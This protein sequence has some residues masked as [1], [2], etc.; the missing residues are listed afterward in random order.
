MSLNLPAHVRR[1]YIHFGF[2]LKEWTKRYRL[3]FDSGAKNK[4]Q[5]CTYRMIAAS[6][7]E[8]E[9]RRERERVRHVQRKIEQERRKHD[10]EQMRHGV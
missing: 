7:A 4:R 1:V 5:H 6:L 8:G 9:T 2:P 3:D 10:K